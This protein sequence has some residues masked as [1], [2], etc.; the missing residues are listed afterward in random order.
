M[1]EVGT[2][3]RLTDPES[4]AV[5]LKACAGVPLPLNLGDI[6]RAIVRKAAVFGLFCEK[7]THEFLV[8]IPEI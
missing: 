2:D 7:G 8:L 6:V 1:I 5:I 3:H 4:L